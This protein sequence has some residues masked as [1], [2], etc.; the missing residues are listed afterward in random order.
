MKWLYVHRKWSIVLLVGLLLL[1][2]TGGALAAEFVDGEDVY[3]L[4]ADQVI[5]DDLYVGSGEI[6]IDGTVKG[7]VYA[8]GGYIEINGVVE[9][10]LVAVGGGIVIRGQVLDDVRVGGGGIEVT[11]IVGDDLIAAGGGGQGMTFPMP[12]GGR[13]IE[14]GIR[15]GS[16]AQVGGDSVILGGGGRIDGH[17]A[18]DLI[19]MMG[20][21]ELL[22]QVDGNADMQV[23][24][25]RVDEGSRVAG[26]LRYSSPDQVAIPGGAAGAVQYDAPQQE[27]A[28]QASLVSQI[29]GWLVRTALILIGFA[30]LG[31]LLL[32][33]APS[34]LARPVAAI[35]EKPLES[36]VYGLV[37]GI[38]LVFVPIVSTLLVVLLWIFWG[39]FPALVMA[40]F[41]IGGLA[42][43]WLFS[44]LITGL[45]LG[46][47][48]LGQAGRE[49][50][51]TVALLVGVLLIVIVGRVPIVGWLV[52]FLSFAL[53]LGGILRSRQSNLADSPGADLTPAGV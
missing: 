12:F 26:T 46:Q 40:F 30:L 24:S 39:T 33:Y 20:T 32:R 6:Y 48:I 37:A 17:I 38:L 15:I 7:D 11:G 53:A 1:A 25:L 5:N 41:L 14:P 51:L 27:T 4:P 34:L 44:P 16:E 28:Q 8:A 23:G 21:V 22:G 36:G 9:G 18:G 35:E 47:R 45:W 31:W 3:R 10:D 42:L 49:G 52:Y 50:T 29:V 43:I 19:A 2:V 13:T